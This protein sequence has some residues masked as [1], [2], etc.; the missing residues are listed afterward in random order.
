MIADLFRDHKK[1]SVIRSTTTAMAR[2][3]R[4][5]GTTVV[6][7]ERHRSSVAM[8]KITTVMDASMSAFQSFSATRDCSVPVENARH[9]VRVARERRSRALQVITALMKVAV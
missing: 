9:A 7:V 3:T 5:H 8:V 1:S 2:W 4:V 6:S